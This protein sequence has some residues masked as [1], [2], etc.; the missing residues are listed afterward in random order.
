[1]FKKHSKAFTLA[2]LLISL[3]I[4]AEIAAF[5]IPKVL[6]AYQNQQKIAIAKEMLGAAGAVYTKLQA[7]GTLVNATGAEFA[8]NMNYISQDSTTIID[9][10]QSTGWGNLNCSTW[11]A[12]C[13][14]LHSGAIIGA[15]DTGAMGGTTFNQSVWLL[16]DVEG[17]Y[18]G[19]HNGFWMQIHGNGRIT[20]DWLDRPNLEPTWF[21]Y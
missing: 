2:E 20:T 11:W 8:R 6:V 17:S 3:L 1:M 7:N 9:D 13:Y 16:V 19:D 15:D 12:K 14:R 4:L 21:R 18:Q 5:A 10:A